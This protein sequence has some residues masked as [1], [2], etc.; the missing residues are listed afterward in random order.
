MPLSRILLILV[1]LCQHIAMAAE[2]IVLHLP[3]DS[4]AMLVS[5]NQPHSHDSHHHDDHEDAHDA[6]VISDASGA[7][8]DP[9]GNIEAHDDAAH[10]HAKH[11][12]GHA[13][14][15]A[16]LFVIASAPAGNECY[17]HKSQ[18][19]GITH[20]PPVPPPNA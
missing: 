10:E 4:H 20:T 19:T 14:V 8:A 16:Q 11:I 7:T 12:H 1:F 6:N 3:D 9:A 15:P 2:P 13:D 5:V 17:L 18:L